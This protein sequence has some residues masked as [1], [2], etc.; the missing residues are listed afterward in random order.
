MALW[1][2]IGQ[3]SSMDANT[4]MTLFRKYVQFHE[5]HDATPSSDESRAAVSTL[6]AQPAKV[7]LSSHSGSS[8]MCESSARV[9]LLQPAGCA[10]L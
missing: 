1:I 7:D 4:R 8:S 5:G 2:G 10:A 9:R 3:P 6:P